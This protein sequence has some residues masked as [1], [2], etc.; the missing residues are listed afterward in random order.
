L[1][2][3][4]SGST[5]ALHADPVVDGN[6]AHPA[7]DGGDDSRELVAHDLRQHRARQRVWPA[8]AGQRPVEV[9]ADIG[10]AQPV[11]SDRDLDL[12]GAWHRFVHVLDT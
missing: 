9:L 11:V 2:A 3:T 5:S 4:D 1:N 12:A 8:G 10:A 7:P 6:V